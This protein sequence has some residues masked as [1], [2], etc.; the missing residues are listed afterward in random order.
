MLYK[1]DFW[2]TIDLVVSQTF[3]KI[4]I[5]NSGRSLGNI[6]RFKG[7]WFSTAET[8][9]NIPLASC[10]L[11]PRLSEVWIMKRN[12]SR[13]KKTFQNRTTN[14]TPH[15][16]H[17]SMWLKFCF[18]LRLFLSTEDLAF[19]RQDGSKLLSTVIIHD[20]TSLLQRRWDGLRIRRARRTSD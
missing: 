7:L 10:Q 18:R 15:K 20:S 11:M 5:S 9:Y 8:V 3:F 17:S 4:K 13:I 2:K 6:R 16:L 12:R 14:S 19:S 1:L